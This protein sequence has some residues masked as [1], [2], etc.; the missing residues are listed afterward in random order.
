MAIE[1]SNRKDETY[2]IKS[3]KTKKGNLTYY[4][5]RKKDKE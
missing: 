1:F 2:Y 5:T 4:M 3:K